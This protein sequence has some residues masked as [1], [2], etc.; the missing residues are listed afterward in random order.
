MNETPTPSDQRGV[1]LLTDK[2]DAELDVKLEKLYDSLPDHIYGMAR[3]PDEA[4]V[5]FFERWCLADPFYM[6]NLWH[7]EDIVDERGRKAKRLVERYFKL[8]SPDRCAALCAAVSANY[9]DAVM[10]L[11]APQEVMQ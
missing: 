11:M 4:F 2:V 9:D 6:W 5:E 8:A 10:R 3:L 1:A 7:N